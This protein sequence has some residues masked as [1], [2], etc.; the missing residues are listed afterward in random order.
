PT[1]GTTLFPCT[2]LFRSELPRVF[3]ALAGEPNTAFADFFLLALLTG[4]RRANV[5]MMRWSDL[6]LAQGVWRIP[7]TKNDESQDVPLVP[8]RSEEH[9]SELQS[10][11][12]LV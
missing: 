6:D 3:A 1:P 7:R 10:P 11:C 8:E 2:T 5:R 4:A 12:N 9:T